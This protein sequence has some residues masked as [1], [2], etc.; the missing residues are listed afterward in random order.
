MNRKDAVDDCP[1]R[2]GID[3][4]ALEQVTTKPCCTGVGHDAGGEHEADAPA[5]PCELKCAFEEQLV[6]I[7]VRAGFDVVDPGLANE[8]REPL[9]IVPPARA[10][11]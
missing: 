6:A 9:R 4:R 3:V 10:D 7:D 1:A 11:L 2:D 5:V 8:V